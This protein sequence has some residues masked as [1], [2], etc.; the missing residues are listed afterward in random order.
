MQSRGPNI[1]LLAIAKLNS[2]DSFVPGKGYT[3]KCSFQ[4]EQVQKIFQSH[5][6]SCLSS[7]LVLV[8]TV[9]FRCHIVRCCES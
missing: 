7:K 1:Q 8:K 5:Q 9:S 6:V 4:R 2:R 3:V